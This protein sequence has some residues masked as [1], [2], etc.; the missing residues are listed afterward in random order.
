MTR[1]PDPDILAALSPENLVAAYGS[2]VFPMVEGGRLMWFSP[3]PRG[4]LPMDGSLHVPRRLRR[5]LRQGRFALT[6]N[7]CFDAVVAA[8][9]R[10]RAEGTWI[11]PEIRIAYRRLHQLGLAHSFEVWPADDPAADQPIGGL[12]GVALGGAFFGESMFHTVTDAGKVALVAGLGHLRAR[13]LI[14]YDIQWTTPN[15]QRYGAFEVPRTDYLRRLDHAIRLDR[16]VHPPKH[17]P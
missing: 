9:A 10:D 15:L 13:G 11:S 1:R 6:V 7:R 8:C 2:G 14:L 17:R 4:L 16:T 5:T 3:D 12:Y